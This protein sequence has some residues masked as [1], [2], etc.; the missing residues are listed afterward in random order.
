[1]N[2]EEQPI[3]R[4]TTVQLEIQESSP[5]T[6]VVKAEGEV[7][8]T[9]WTDAGLSRA[10]YVD[11]PADGIQDYTFS[12]MPPSGPSGDQITPVE[13]E[14]RWPG[15]ADWVKGVRVTSETN[16]IEEMLR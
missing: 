4:V 2:R 15:Y 9:G 16:E 11:P 6:L 14:D 5:P 3:Y 1:M 13:A 12:A 7:R 8:T 10:V